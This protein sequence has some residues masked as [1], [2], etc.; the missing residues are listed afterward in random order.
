MKKNYLLTALFALCI[1]FVGYSQNGLIGDGF[2]NNSWDSVI[3]M[4]FQNQLGLQE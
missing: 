4:T 1:S 2:G 3:L